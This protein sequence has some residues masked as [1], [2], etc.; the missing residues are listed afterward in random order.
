MELCQRSEQTRGVRDQKTFLKRETP[1]YRHG[2][3]GTWLKGLEGNR[4]GNRPPKHLWKRK[5]VTQSGQRSCVENRLTAGKRREP[6][7]FNVRNH[8][9]K[10]RIEGHR[11]LMAGYGPWGSTG[12]KGG[13]GGEEELKKKFST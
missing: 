2:V 9:Q 10:K 1:G 12:K 6:L 3:N 5:T 13:N 8:Y 7:G 11:V 4:R